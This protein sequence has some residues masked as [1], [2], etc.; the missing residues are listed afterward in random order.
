MVLTD[1]FSFGSLKIH[2]VN[3][4]V[5]L[6]QFWKFTKAFPAVPQK[7]RKYIRKSVILIDWCYW[8]TKDNIFNKIIAVSLKKSTTFKL[9]ITKDHLG[10]IHRWAIS[11]KKQR[12]SSYLSSTTDTTGIP[13]RE[14][15]ESTTRISSPILK[16]VSPSPC[17]TKQ[18]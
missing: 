10:G 1:S 8:N 7:L 18:E 15:L 6:Q 17:N 12:F 16:S 3:P 11:W 13:M 9:F 14:K 5:L 2:T 4:R